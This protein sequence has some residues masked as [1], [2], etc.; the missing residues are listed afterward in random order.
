MAKARLRQPV[1]SLLIFSMCAMAACGSATKN[2]AL[3][4]AE[5]SVPYTWVKIKGT[6][7]KN[8]MFDVSIEYGP[9]GTGWLAYSQVQIPKFINTHIAK[10]TDG[11]ATWRHVTQVGASHESTVN[12]HGKAIEGVWRDET[13]CLLYDPTDHPQRRWKLLTN[14]Y[15]TA[16]PFKPQ[17]RFMG[18]GTINIRYAANPAGPWSTPECLVGHDDDCRISMRQA[19]RSLAG[20]RMNTEPG[21]VVDDKGTIYLTLDA[22]T[23][24]SGLGDWKNYRVILLSS[25]NHGKTWKYIRTILSHE[26]AKRFGYLVFTG[27]SLTKVKGKF[28]LLATPSGG[29]KTKNR[30][31]DGTMVF[32]FADIAKGQLVATQQRQPKILLRLKPSRGSGGLADYDKKNTAGGVIFSQTS[33]WWFPQVFRIFQTGHGILEN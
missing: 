32:E 25:S 7:P 10:S 3:A 24:Q 18:D 11:G 20:I 6:P 1:L 27:T 23:T 21:A 8:G 29:I 31:H 12:K 33:M 2:D 15:F 5:P 17:N 9:D 4:A 28:Y 26:D 19:D 30:G 13:P 22:A 14:H 16:K